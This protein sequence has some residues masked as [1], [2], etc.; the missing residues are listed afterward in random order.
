MIAV[1]HGG[2]AVCLLVDHVEGLSD[3]AEDDLVPPPPI[4]AGTSADWLDYVTHRPTG[5]LVGVINVK[6]ALSRASLTG[7]EAFATSV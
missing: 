5:E 1:R 4:V 6:G 3:V 7:V 2:K